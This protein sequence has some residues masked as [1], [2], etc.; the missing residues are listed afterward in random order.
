M[1]PAPCPLSVPWCHPGQMTSMPGV[2][3][4][5]VVMGAVPHKGHHDTR[6]CWGAQVLPGSTVSWRLTILCT[7][8]C[9]SLMKCLLSQ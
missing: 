1:L 8:L 3:E 4:V 6:D 9:G 5:D 2:G 7:G